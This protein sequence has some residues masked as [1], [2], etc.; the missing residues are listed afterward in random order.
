M[1]KKKGLAP[2]VIFFHV[3]DS[4][5]KGLTGTGLAI[6]QRK[7]FLICPI[8]PSTYISQQLIKRFQKMVNIFFP[9]DQGGVEPKYI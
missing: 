2:N 1:K 5:Q 9:Y 4:F 8:D 7:A 6:A 3:P